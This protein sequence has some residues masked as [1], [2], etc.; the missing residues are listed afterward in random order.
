M[1]GES[2]DEAAAPALH[3]STDRPMR[4]DARR[5]IDTLL[6]AA[7]KVF[8]TSGVDA[9][10]RE[11]A[12]QAGVGVGTI[13]RHFPQRA[14]L[15]AAVFRHEVDACA[16][17][18]ILLA[19]ERAPGEA[20]DRWMQRYVD[21]IV[22]KRGLAAALHSG[23]AAFETLPAYFDKRLEPALQG[24]LDGAIAAGELR[25]DANPRDLLRAVAS[26]CMPSS[27]GD[28]APA[29]RLVGLL[30]DGLRYRAKSARA[31]ACPLTGTY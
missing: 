31:S 19:A 6:Q 8:A 5:N 20:L 26:L 12:E 17:A 16:D 11:I 4:A 7:K 3:G 29:R 25:S 24:L 18:A 28:P 27:D 21:F 10:M 22:A 30:I 9:P 13:Y 14:D 1:S 23:A 15:V 2:E